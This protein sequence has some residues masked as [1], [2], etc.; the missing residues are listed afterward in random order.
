MKIDVMARSEAVAATMAA[1]KAALANGVD[2]GTLHQAKAHLLE[3]AARDELFPFSA[4]PL[5][6]G[7]VVERTY[8]LHQEAG[9]G[10]ALYV[11]AAG[12]AQSYGPHD[13]GDSWAIVVAVR[14]RE[15]HCFYKRRD[16]GKVAG[17]AEI[18][19][20]GTLIVEPGTGIAM[21]P[22]AIHAIEAFEEAPLLHLHCYARPFESMT[23]RRE[24]DQ[25][26]GTY[27]YSNDVGVIELPPGSE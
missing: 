4:F 24:Y 17:R 23:N 18:E 2:A 22:G 26:A 10:T 6:Q 20:T 19:E 12:A 15:K 11:N 14:G 16:D 21:V 8:L 9:D 25:A 1:M 5:P 27:R 7:E 13:H 3:L